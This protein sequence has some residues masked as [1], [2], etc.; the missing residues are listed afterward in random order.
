MWTSKLRSN[1]F[2]YN[3]NVLNKCNTEGESEGIHGIALLTK[4]SCTPFVK[5][6]NG[7][8]KCAIWC[9]IDR[10]LIC[11]NALLGAIYIP[12]ETSRHSYLEIFDEI[13]QDILEFSSDKECCIILAGDFNARVGNLSDTDIAKP[14]INDDITESDDLGCFQ[15]ARQ[16]QDMTIN[17][18]GRR[19]VSLCKTM[20]LCLLNGR[21][22]QDKNI[23]HF[24]SKNVSVVDYIMVS[25]SLSYMVTDFVVEDIDVLL[26]DIH[27]PI[28]CTIQT[29]DKLYYPR[30]VPIE[31]LQ[32]IILPRKP[33]WDAS[34][35]LEFKQNIDEVT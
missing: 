20:K 6:L 24:T 16:T 7:V 28:H 25:H 31:D 8:S 9:K 18:Y 1:D 11:K 26:S 32:R 27:S 13:E 35:E 14:H 19:L 4:K 2:G 30:S 33:K 17:R 23:G 15:L 3:L 5:V 12:P 34:K 10:K 29:S 21:V 22:G